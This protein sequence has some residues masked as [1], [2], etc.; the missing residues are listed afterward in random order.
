MMQTA[1]SGRGMLLEARR[2]RT[3]SSYM[4]PVANSSIV[5]TLKRL[6]GLEILSLN[7]SRERSTNYQISDDIAAS[8]STLTHLTRTLTCN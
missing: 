6:T 3:A 2:R 7:I 8:V 5:N 4:H 1:S